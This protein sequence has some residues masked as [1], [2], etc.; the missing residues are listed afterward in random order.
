MVSGLERRRPADLAEMKEARGIQVLGS[1]PLDR[2]GARKALLA[3]VP[4]QTRRLRSAFD[5]V[6]AQI[7]R[8]PTA[9]RLTE[10]GERLADQYAALIVTAA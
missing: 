2:R 6:A 3:Q 7:E 5:A 10:E 4:A 1:V 9:V 8:G